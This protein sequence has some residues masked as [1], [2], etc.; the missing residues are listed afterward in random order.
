[1]KLYKDAGIR[2]V[3]MVLYPH[4]R[5]EILNESERDDAMKAIADFIKETIGDE[6]R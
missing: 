1:M 4:G 5:H 6:R 2:D 3:R